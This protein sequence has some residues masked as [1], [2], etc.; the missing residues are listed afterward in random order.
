MRRKVRGVKWIDNA[1]R[2]RAGTISSSQERSLATE[3]RVTAMWGYKEKNDEKIMM[4]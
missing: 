1:R 3:E 4:Y 2:L